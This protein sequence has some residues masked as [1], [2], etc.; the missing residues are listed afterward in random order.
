MFVGDFPAVLDKNNRLV[1]P[2]D[3]RKAMSSAEPE[4]ELKKGFFLTIGFRA[5]WLE[6]HPHALFKKRTDQL[7]EKYPETDIVGRNW[8]RDVVTA[9]KIIRLD[10]QHRFVLPEELKLAAGI[11]SEV[12][13]A[14]HWDR[15]E[16]WDR[17]RYVTH[18]S[19]RVGKQAPPD[20]KE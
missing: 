15:I 3:F 5:E 14:A 13:F 10:S 2:A 18:K 6:M 8:L 7:Y 1:L 12:Y 9:A 17:D 11:Q 16:I 19:G 4:V 20:V